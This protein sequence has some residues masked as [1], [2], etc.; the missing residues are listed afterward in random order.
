MLMGWAEECQVCGP[1][2]LSK[3]TLKMQFS[4]KNILCNGLEN[5]VFPAILFL[6]VNFPISHYMVFKMNADAIHSGQYICEKTLI[7]SIPSS[8]VI[9]NFLEVLN[10]TILSKFKYARRI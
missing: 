1:G 3:I 10:S 9:T 8:P 2:L 5:R 4:Y 6:S 7:Q